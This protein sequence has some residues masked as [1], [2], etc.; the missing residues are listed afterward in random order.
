MF[1]LLVDNLSVSRFQRFSVI[2]QANTLN[3]KW[4]FVI[5]KMSDL[6]SYWC[7]FMDIEIFQFVLVNSDIRVFVNCV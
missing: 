2:L 7:I 6:K 5:V 1:A 3:I 4:I